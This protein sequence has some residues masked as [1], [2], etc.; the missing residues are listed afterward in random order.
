[1]NY[2]VNIPSLQTNFPPVF[3][4]PPLLLDFAG[5]LAQKERGSLGYFALQSERFDDYWIENGTDLHENFAFFIRD[6]TGG[7]IGF[8]L[9]DE[10]ALA[11]PPVVMV[12]SEGELRI[13]SGTL[14]EFLERL[15]AGKTQAPD[16]DSRD[17]EDGNAPTELT[18]WLASHVSGTS[19]QN[20]RQPPDLGQWMDAWGQQQREWIDKD[21]LHLQIADK[22]RKYVKPNAEPW[23]TAAFDVLLVGTQFKMWHRS[24]GPQPMPPIEVADLEPLFRSIRE[25]RAHRFPGRGLWFTSWVTVGSHGGAKLSCNFMEQPTILDERPMVPNSDYELDFRDFP[26]SNHWMPEWFR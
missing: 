16:L 15:A 20:L 9:Y 21:A 13:L 18:Q 26:R 24:F 12:G 5:W 8:W 2:T 10:T 19:V 7:Q 25:Q 3:P 23:E 22:L 11:S 1:M 17:D 4:A 6:P 14:D